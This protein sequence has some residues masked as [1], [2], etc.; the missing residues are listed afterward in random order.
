MSTYWPRFAPA[1]V[2]IASLD[3]RIKCPTEAKV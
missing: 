3:T 2:M 1:C